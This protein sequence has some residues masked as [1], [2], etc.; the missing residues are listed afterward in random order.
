ML[1]SHYMRQQSIFYPEKHRRA[2]WPH[3]CLT[4]EPNKLNK[5]KCNFLIFVWKKTECGFTTIVPG[6]ATFQ[7]QSLLNCWIEISYSLLIWFLS[8]QY[9]ESCTWHIEKHG[10]RT[11]QNQ[12]KLA[13]RIGKPDTSVK[14]ICFV[15]MH[16]S[17]IIKFSKEAKI[18][19][20][21]IRGL[22]Y[23]RLRSNFEILSLETYFSWIFKI[24]G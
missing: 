13:P 2:T 15:W 19:K 6:N 5:I 10:C 1:Q 3:L 24:A 18:V 12:P 14:K 8:I 7:R 21:T 9:T 16:F 17:K 22:P 11:L 23:G 4:L 20:F